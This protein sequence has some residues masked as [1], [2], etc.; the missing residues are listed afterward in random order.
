MFLLRG[1]VL[2]CKIGVLK[3]LL[4]TAVACLSAKMPFFCLFVYK[5][6]KGLK[7]NLT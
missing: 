4:P 2:N 3:M 1:N 5:P 6:L 7:K